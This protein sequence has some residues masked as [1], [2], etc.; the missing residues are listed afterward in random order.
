MSIS[1]YGKN[2]ILN[3]MFNATAYSETNTWLSYHTAD[4]GLTGANEVTGGSY[5]RQQMSFGT[6]AAGA[7]AN[8]TAETTTMPAVTATH[9]GLWNAVST[10]DF[11]WGGPLNA[12][13]VFAASETAELAS[14]D[15]DII[16]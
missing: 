5:A 15:L 10:G 3:A 2:S 8:D 11:L 12:S 16:L 13:T 1:T 4:P 7:V 9:W 6:V 14:G